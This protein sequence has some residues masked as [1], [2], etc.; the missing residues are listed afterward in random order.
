MG[1]CQENNIKVTGQKEKY[2]NKIIS[3]CIEP[4]AFMNFKKNRAKILGDKMF[5]TEEP[6]HIKMLRE[7]KEKDAADRLRER[8]MKLELKFETD[9]AKLR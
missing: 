8:Q 5:V 1:L 3:M 6:Y 4:K 7:L 2:N 9:S